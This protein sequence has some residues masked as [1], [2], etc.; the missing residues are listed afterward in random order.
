MQ[1]CSYYFFLPNLNSNF[2]TDEKILTIYGNS[3]L[4]MSQPKIL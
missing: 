1:V 2:Q 3:S 4:K